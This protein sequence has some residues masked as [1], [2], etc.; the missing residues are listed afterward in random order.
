ML[1]AEIVLRKEPFFLTVAEEGLLGFFL[2]KLKGNDFRGL[3]GSR[4]A[5]GEDYGIMTVVANIRDCGLVGY[6]LGAAA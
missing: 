2:I 4:D 5:L 1:G 3:E 6:D